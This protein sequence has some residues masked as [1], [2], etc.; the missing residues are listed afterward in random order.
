MGG[1][2][3]AVRGLVGRRRQL[4]V[5]AGGKLDALSPLATLRR[6]YSVAR[7]S[8]GRVLRAV[9]DFASGDRFTLR[10]SDGQVTAETLDTQPGES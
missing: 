4:L 6:G 7:A 8:D 10:V 3:H 1:L 5:A 2:E 9:R